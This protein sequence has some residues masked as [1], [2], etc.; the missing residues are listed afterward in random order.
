MP[1]PVGKAALTLVRYM[2]RPINNTL[3]KKF[4]VQHSVE[5]QGIGYRF[6]QNIGQRCNRFEVALNRIVIQQKGLGEVREI[7]ADLAFSKGVDY[8]T[9]IIFFYF[10]MFGIAIYEM[11]KAYRSGKKTSQRLN[12][13]TDNSKIFKT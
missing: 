2:L 5:K 4:K 8:F 13:A 10:V 12:T 11:D 6:F 3:I 1:I 7:P 9:E